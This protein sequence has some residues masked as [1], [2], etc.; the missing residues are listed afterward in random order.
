MKKLFLIGAVALAFSQT[1]LAHDETVKGKVEFNKDTQII[2]AEVLKLVSALEEKGI[3]PANTKL[4]IDL[5]DL[6][7]SNVIEHNCCTII[8]RTTTET[9]CPCT[10]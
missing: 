8:T 9:M 4:T 5:K 3:D 1:A 6:R 2:Q 7:G 10:E